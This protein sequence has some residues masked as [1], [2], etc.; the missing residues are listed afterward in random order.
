[1]DAVALA[2]NNFSKRISQI[3]MQAV[4]ILKLRLQQPTCMTIL[5]LAFTSVAW[6]M[7]L[8]EILCMFGV[9]SSHV[10]KPTA[11]YITKG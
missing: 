8:F 9:W 10:G 5:N 1:M 7:P 11:L 6:L 4:V 2:L 3:Y